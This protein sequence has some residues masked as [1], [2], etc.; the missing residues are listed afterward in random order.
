MEFLLVTLDP[1]FV[2]GQ[3]SQRIDRD[4]HDSFRSAVCRNS[5]GP[6][7]HSRE[8]ALARCAGLWN[9]DGAVVM[10][11]NIF[12]HKEH[13]KERGEHPNMIELI[14]TAAREVERPIV[15][16]IAIISI[17]AYLPIFTLQRV[18]GRLFTPM[19]WTVAFALLGALLF[20]LLIAPVLC[21]LL[22]PKGEIREWRNPRTS[23]A[24][25]TLS[26]ATRLAFQPHEDD[27]G[28]G[29]PRRSP[30]VLLSRLQRRHRFRVPAAP[31]RRGDLGTRDAGS[32]HWPE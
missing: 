27:P 31:R 7:P 5:A 16:A 4:H 20:A 6:E 22:F 11:E 10:I 19:A 18:E 26:P 2:P 30:P 28:R 29:A 12:R 3:W 17:L 24:A 21:T 9:G 13:A 32:E 25:G 1:I 14:I 23:L 8:P 15:Y